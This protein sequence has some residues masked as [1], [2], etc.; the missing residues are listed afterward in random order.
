M[1]S[2]VDSPVPIRILAT[3]ESL[4][5]TATSAILGSAGSR[6]LTRISPQT[7]CIPVPIRESPVGRGACRQGRRFRDGPVRRRWRYTAGRDPRAVQLESERKYC[8][9]RRPEV[10]SRPRHE[11]RQRHRSGDRAAA[12]VRARPR[13]PAVRRGHDGR[14]HRRLDDVFN[15]TSSTTPPTSPGR[16]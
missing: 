5:C 9:P 7:V 16:R 6:F 13:L 4:T 8:V 12:R 10:L 14:P 1:G 15:G 2:T 3:F 11:P